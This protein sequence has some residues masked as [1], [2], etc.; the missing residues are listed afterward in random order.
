MFSHMSA[1]LNGLH[2]V[3]AYQVSSLFQEEFN[4]H[5]DLHTAAWY[6][7]LNTTR[8]FAMRLD[9]ICALFV[10]SVALS[11]VP[12]AASKYRFSLS[13]YLPKPTTPLV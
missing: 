6:M 2:T 1:T 12:A 11:S 3:R 9:L 5:Q 10:S 8:W 4:H 7:F 13:V